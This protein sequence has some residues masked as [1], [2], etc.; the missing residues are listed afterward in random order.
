MIEVKDIANI[1]DEEITVEPL[2]FDA[3]QFANIHEFAKAMFTAGEKYVNTEDI[4]VRYAKP[5]NKETN[6]VAIQFH[7][8]RSKAKIFQKYMEQKN[9]P[10]NFVLDSN[11]EIKSCIKFFNSL[12]VKGENGEPLLSKETDYTRDIKEIYKKGENKI[13][14]TIE[15]VKQEDN[16][17]I[18]LDYVIVA[19]D[20]KEYTYEE[21][22]NAI[23]KNILK[24]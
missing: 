3:K 8:L 6:E 21:K 19:A 24:L 22:K 1:K 13:L 18:Q 10:I 12:G 4:I 11:K 20:F 9:T 5:I 16:N 2:I 23:E 17:Y 14:V 7:I 15:N